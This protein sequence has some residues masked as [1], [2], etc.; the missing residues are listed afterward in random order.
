M[1]RPSPHHRLRAIMTEILLTPLRTGLQGLLLFGVWG[2][3]R[4][5]VRIARLGC[6]GIATMSLLLILFA[7]GPAGAWAQ[8][9]AAPAHA[10]TLYVEPFSAGGKATLLHDSLVRELAKNHR[11]RLA[12]SASGADFVVKGTGQVW[13]RG[14]VSA[15]S[16]TPANSRQP[17]YGGYLS[18]EV[19]GAGGQPLWS[20]LA[21][22]G[23]MAWNNI[24]EN[25]AD[26]ATHK[27]EEAQESGAIVAGN[28]APSDSL[29]QTELLGAGAT[30]PAPLYQKWFEDFEGL[31]P[32]V[33]IRYAPVGSERGTERLVAGQLAFAGSDVAPELMT[34]T[35]SASHLR[36]V[37]S[38]LGAVVPVYHLDG[39]VQ[40][41]HFTSEALAEIYLGRVRRWNDAAI[42]RSN[43]GVHLPD[44]DIVVI[45]RSDGSGTTWWW[46]DY[47]SKVSRD[48]SS[49][50]GRGVTLHWPAGSGVEG[51]EGVAETVEKTPNSIGYV[52]L[53]YAVQR[54]LSFAAVRNRSGEYVH[55]DLDS[56]EEAAKSA[57]GGVAGD[58]TD[59]PG[60]NAYP[61][62]AFTW[63][64]TPSETR[65]AAKTAALAE[66]LRW[67]LTSG[68]KECSALGYAPLP[69]E[70]AEEQ[71]RMLS[72]H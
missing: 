5:R 18:I 36:R 29:A 25:L 66:L 60:R 15:N 30:F 24:V 72:T 3:I 13:V 8:S 27:L 31:H 21:T 67:V 65:D 70:T 59:P 9:A 54:Q 48:W 4:H 26:Q 39:S 32:G 38:V 47:L 49:S 28:P 42:R 45:H 33:H 58:I 14:Y 61:I 43:P 62:A 12:D 35:Q 19:V 10:T 40:D 2:L 20:W 55:A 63:L 34:D 69:R 71:I 56:L 6:A 1:S 52:E 37:A 41:L 57:G 17:V 46:S 16:R 64:L 68:Q 53:A 51:S 7:L 11:F 50:V 22:P 44:A 23:R